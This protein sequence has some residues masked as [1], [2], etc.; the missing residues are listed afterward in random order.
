MALNFRFCC[1]VPSG[2]F[3]KNS[4]TGEAKIF[5]KMET[6]CWKLLVK[7]GLQPEGANCSHLETVI[8]EIRYFFFGKEKT[9]TTKFCQ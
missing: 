2:R 4:G 3:G 8:N 1:I 9:T 7:V 6:E 5:A